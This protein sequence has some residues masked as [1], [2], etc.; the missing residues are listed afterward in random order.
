MNKGKSA[1]IYDITIEHI[2]QAGDSLES[3]L[4]KIINTIFHH[5]SVPDM[6]KVGLLTPVFK[7]K[8][9]KSCARNYRGITVLHVNNTNIIETILKQR[10]NPAVVKHKIELREDLR[11]GHHRRTQ[12]YQ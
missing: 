7:N 5:G 6:L 10:I 8:G 9:D 12:H 2:T 11:K 3:P 4:L 1:D